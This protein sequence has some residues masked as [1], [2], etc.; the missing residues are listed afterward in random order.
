[1]TSRRQFIQSVPL[2]V[3]ALF[4]THHAF[5]ADLDPKDP[6]AVALG[7]VPDAAR[8]DKAKFPKYA[9]GQTCGNCALYQGKPADASGLCPLFAGKTVAA[10]GWCNAY[11]KKA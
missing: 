11:V 8:V 5:A 2:W 10:R 4:A 1:M 7:Y 9:T 6:Q 3:S